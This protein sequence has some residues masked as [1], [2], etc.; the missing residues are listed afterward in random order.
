MTEQFEA[1]EGSV[2]HNMVGYIV[3]KSHGSC[4]ALCNHEEVPFSRQ[5]VIQGREEECH[6]SL[7]RYF[8]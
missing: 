8:M 2:R 7:L 5:M 4:V 3:E 1:V 6:L